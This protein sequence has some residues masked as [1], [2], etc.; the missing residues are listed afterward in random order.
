VD[1]HLDGGTFPTRVLQPAFKSAGV[2]GVTMHGLRHT[3]ASWLLA[4]GADLQVVK[5]RLGHAKIATT[6]GYL[7]TLPSA[8]ETALGKIRA[9][10]VSSGELDAGKKEIDELKAALVSVTLRLTQSTAEA[11]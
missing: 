8:D 6:E 11:P 4:G 10:R 7:H 9:D 2:E 3:H 1:P 5:E